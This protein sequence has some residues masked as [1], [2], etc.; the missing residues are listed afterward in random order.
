MVF[1]HPFHAVFELCHDFGKLLYRH[2]R[3]VGFLELTNH[4]YLIQAVNQLLEAFLFQTVAQRLELLHIVHRQPGQVT[5]AILADGFTALLADALDATNKCHRLFQAF[6]HL[7]GVA[8]HL[9]GFAAFIGFKLTNKSKGLTLIHRG[10]HARALCLDQ[11]TILC[12][13]HH[14]NKQPPVI[15]HFQVLFVSSTNSCH[16]TSSNH[17]LFALLGFFC[18][19]RWAFY[20][21]SASLSV[22]SA[23]DSLLGASCSVSGIVSPSSYSSASCSDGFL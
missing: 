1:H 6:R 8:L 15:L 17:G 14:G 10:K 20:C 2:C 22:C 21:S 9:K 7:S 18:C 11:L 12:E 13:G 19:I 5:I 3:A 4:L 16:D 23:S